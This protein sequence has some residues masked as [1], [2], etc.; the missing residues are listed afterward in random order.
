[1]HYMTKPFLICLTILGVTIGFS[2]ISPAFGG[3]KQDPLMLAS[4]EGPA[5]HLPPESSDAP[6][7]HE[8]PSDIDAPEPAEAHQDIPPQDGHII[9]PDPDAKES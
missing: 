5:L 4:S 7:G 1:M 2:V 3:E 8:P 6:P 9:P